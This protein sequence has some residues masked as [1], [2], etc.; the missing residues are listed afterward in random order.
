MQAI[1]AALVV[2][3]SLALLLPEFPASR[4]AGV[5]GLWGA[6]GALAAAIGPTLG[7][8]LVEGPGW[9]WIFLVNAPIVAVAVFTGRRVLRESRAEGTP[10]RA[11][12][13]GVLLVTGV[14][15]L[16]SLALVQGGS[17]GWG[18]ARIIAAFVASAVLLPLLVM[19][20][21]H[22]ATP[23]LPVRLFANATFSLATIGLLLFGAAFFAIILANVLF[24]T[25]VWQYSVLRAAVALLPSPLIAAVS[26][27]IAGRLADRFGFRVVIVPGAL[28]MV[29]GTLWLATRTTSEPAYLT[30]FLPGSVLVGLSIGFAFAA[31][32]AAGASALGPQ[33][34]GSGSA[35]G[36]SARQ[37]GAVLGIAVLVAVLGEP[38]PADALGAFHRSWLVIAGFAAAAAAV[39]TGLRRPPASSP[40]PG[41]PSPHLAAG[42][43]PLPK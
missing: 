4:R 43:R 25:G 19:R 17:W 24:L 29:G 5:V 41:K 34:F 16:L 15:G 39:S 9:R 42:A 14:F 1:G 2:P 31:L 12:Y 27:P 10:G 26:A 22:H 38:A 40:A 7:A 28:C 20:S 35:V 11:D 33:D 37:L 36:A 30:D 6:A 23:V 18:S 21:L 32:G 13:L 3:A 8:L